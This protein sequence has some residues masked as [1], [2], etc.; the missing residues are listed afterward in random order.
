MITNNE[1]EKLVLNDKEKEITFVHKGEEHTARARKEGDS[2]YKVVEGALN[3]KR[4]SVMSL[5]VKTIILF[6][7]IALYSC[8]TSGDDMIQEEVPTFDTFSK[9]LIDHLDSN[10]VI[11]DSALY[12]FQGRTNCELK[13]DEYSLMFAHTRNETYLKQQDL[14]TDSSLYFNRCLQKLSKFTNDRLK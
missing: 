4:V 8:D 6:F 5:I 10:N 14:Y 3:G 12:Y 1:I 13:R 7:S 2:Y 9:R 11:L